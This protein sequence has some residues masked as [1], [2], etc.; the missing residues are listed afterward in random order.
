MSP[1][2]HAGF[3]SLRCS[4]LHPGVVQPSGS[5][6]GTDLFRTPLEEAPMERVESGRHLRSRMYAKLSKENSFD[7][8]D[9]RTISG[10]D[11]GWVS[12]LVN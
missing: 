2:G 12:E 1:R 3:G 9:A 11:L 5:L 10:P 8:V 6:T 4:N 7:H